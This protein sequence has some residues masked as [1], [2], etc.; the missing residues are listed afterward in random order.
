MLAVMGSILSARILHYAAK[1]IWI[2]TTMASFISKSPGD[3]HVSCFPNILPVQSTV[4][5]WKRAAPGASGDS[6]S[7]LGDG[8]TVTSGGSYANN[9]ATAEHPPG[10]RRCRQQRCR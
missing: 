10:S 2:L 5:G 4:R 6:L 8:M 7:I 1:K 3:N 9:R